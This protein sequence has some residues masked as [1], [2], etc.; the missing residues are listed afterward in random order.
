MP[1]TPVQTADALRQAAAAAVTALP[2]VI[3]LEPTL[4]NA[5]L[6]LR[7]ATVA[8]AVPGRPTVY[9]AADGIRL[10]R[11]GDL[12]DLRVDITVTTTQAANRTAQAVHDALQAV[13]TAHQLTPGQI[14]VVVL[15]L[16]P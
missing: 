5:L 15:R 11:R 14:T 4:T 6:R 10:A 12:I 13:I 7:T 16:Q 9:S 3:R 2:G 8:K 1:E